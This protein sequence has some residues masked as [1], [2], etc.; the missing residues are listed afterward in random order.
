V[1]P[2][3]PDLFASLGFELAALLVTSMMGV[4]VAL[5]RAR[6]LLSIQEKQNKALAQELKE[7][8]S[9]S[10]SLSVIVT[11][12]IERLADRDR[13][14]ERQR[15]I[16]DDYRRQARAEGW[17]DE[18]TRTEVFRP[19]RPVTRL[20]LLSDPPH[21]P[22]KLEQLDPRELARTDPPRSL[23]PPPTEPPRPRKR[24]R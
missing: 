13:A 2:D 17:S 22:D 15:L 12:Q 10:E 23:E 19:L 21:P 24:P 11:D 5:G 20:E 4:S 3:L 14:I 1:T 8:K 7:H 6:V 9:K 16:I 18:K